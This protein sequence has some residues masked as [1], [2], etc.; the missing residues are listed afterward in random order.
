MKV[1]TYIFALSMVAGAAQAD[2][3]VDAGTIIGRLCG[4]NQ[5][6]HTAALGDVLPNPD[7]YYVRSL[8]TQIS[9]GDARIV[10]AVGTAF[11]LC[12]RWAATPDMDASR[13]INLAGHQVVKYLFVPATLPEVRTGS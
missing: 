2:T 6:S 10:Q 7:G 5:I 9:Y 3:A 13:A 1:S 4:Q 12:T 8:Q 11:H